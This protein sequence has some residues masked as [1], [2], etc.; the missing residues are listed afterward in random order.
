MQHASWWRERDSGQR[1]RLEGE[2]GGGKGECVAVC[3]KVWRWIVVHGVDESAGEAVTSAREGGRGK[4]YAEQV[5]CAVG[6]SV[7]KAK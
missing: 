7:E 4:V 3:F 1:L 2:S 6:G 5:A